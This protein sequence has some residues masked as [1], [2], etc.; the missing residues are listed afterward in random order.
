MRIPQKALNRLLPN[1]LATIDPSSFPQQAEAIHSPAKWV[2]IGAA[3]RTGKTFAGARIFVRKLLDDYVAMP[4][5]ADREYWC[6]APTFD[7]C[8]AQKLELLKLIPEWLIDWERQGDKKA[9]FD[10]SHG[11]GFLFLAG[12][13]TVMFKSAERPER[14]VAFKLRG[15]WWTEIAR[16]KVAAWPNIYARLSNYADS[17]FVADTSPLGRCWFYKDVWAPALAG[18]FRNASVHTWRATDSPFVPREVIEEARTNLPP[19]WFAREFEASWDALQ[20]QIYSIND[21]VH[22]RDCPFEPQWAIVSCDLNTTSTHAAEFVW[23]YGTGRGS[24]VR[25]WVAGAY[26]RVIGLDY[27]SYAHDIADR[28][29]TLTLR[30]GV[31]RVRLVVDPSMHRDMKA[32]LMALGVTPRNAIN[33]IL[34]G[35][36]TLGSALS[37]LPGAGPRMTFSPDCRGVVDQLRQMRWVVASDGVVRPTPDKTLDDGWAD[38]CRYLAMDAFQHLSG[39]QQVA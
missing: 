22:I 10:G 8:R 21:D 15:I 39:A 5:G 28:V 20:G 17:W 24:A 36:R 2:L 19:E 12:G 4:W 16:S 25:V 31:G 1:L 33:D 29:K 26:R 18:G 9:F 35:V 30:F 38:A 37:P 13:A 34:P 27:D 6:V 23:A 7:D 32:K 11:R 14:L 3:S